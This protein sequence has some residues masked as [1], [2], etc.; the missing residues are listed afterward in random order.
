MSLYN[1]S[2]SLDPNF[3]PFPQGSSAPSSAV[4]GSFP[5][6]SP[7]LTPTM[8][9]PNGFNQGYMQETNG[10]V[11]ISLNT[12]TTDQKYLNSAQ[13]AFV[14]SENI[15]NKNNHRLL[16]LQ[17]VNKLIVEGSTP[18]PNQTNMGPLNTKKAIMARFK[19][20]GVVVNTDTDNSTRNYNDATSRLARSFTVVTW[21]DSFV[22]DYWS[23]NSN[24][25]YPY[26][27]CFLV[28]KRVRL[29][30]SDG[31]Q[32]NL[33]VSAADSNECFV[34]SKQHSLQVNFNYHYWQ[35]V[36]YSCRQGCLPSKK[37]INEYSC[38]IN[39][40]TK[41]YYELGTY[42][43]IGRVHEY[44]DIA[45]KSFFEGRDEYSVSR[46]V[47]HMHYNGQA[48]PLQFYLKIDDE[49]KLI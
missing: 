25:L 39:G 7:F 20:L 30:E 45:K 21:G 36:P 22:H 47:Y 24:R 4:D 43:R 23:N 34:D 37:L 41:N 40:E 35:F 15:G 27:D 11:K 19:C 38:E 3:N 10:Q 48:R 5:G 46:D 16:S 29:N 28:L 44:A 31:F 18:M 13:L 8:Q 32:T 17:A 6:G 26:D 33:T 14:D 2:S 42:I 1:Y 49:S 9:N 12:R